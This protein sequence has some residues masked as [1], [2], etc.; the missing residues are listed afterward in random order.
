[1]K[2]ATALIGT[3]ALIVLPHAAFA[4]TSTSQNISTCSDEIRSQLGA[5]AGEADL[6]F[7][8]VKGNSRV[9]T[10]SFRIDADGERD[11]VTCKVRRDNSVEVIWGKTVKP[12]MSKSVEAKAST[13][14]GE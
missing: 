14:A 11:K 5:T 3:A 12:K 6:D 10:L 7:K 1:M 13:T 4:S 2:I 8:T 9:Q